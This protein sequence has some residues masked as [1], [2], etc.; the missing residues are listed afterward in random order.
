MD[1]D[2]PT[3]DDRLERAG[4]LLRAVAWGAAALFGIAIVRGW[5]SRGR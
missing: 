3:A 4:N 2:K 5:M 1:V